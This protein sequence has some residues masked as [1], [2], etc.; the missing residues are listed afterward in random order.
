[1]NDRMNP[2]SY[3]GIVKAV[4]PDNFLEVTSLHDSVV[5]NGSATIRIPCNKVFPD[6]Q[7]FTT[8]YDVGD[9]VI[10]HGCTGRIHM[11]WPIQRHGLRA[12]YP[13]DASLD[14]QVPRYSLLL[15]PL[16]HDQT[17]P[18]LVADYGQDIKRRPSSFRFKVGDAV[19]IYDSIHVAPLNDRSYYKLINSTMI[20]AEVT[21]VDVSKGAEDIIV[22]MYECSF[23]K[24][25]SCLI[26][27]D[28]DEGISSV[29]ANPRER[30]FDAIEQNCSREHLGFLC[31]HFDIDV[32]TFS[33]LVVSK[34]VESASLQAL[35]WLQNECKLDVLSFKDELGNNL[36]HL[37]AKSAHATRFIREAGRG[38]CNI[39]EESLLDFSR[40]KYEIFSHLNNEGEL[41]IQTIIRRG[42]AK[43][44]DAALSP[45]CGFA[46]DLCIGISLREN[47]LDLILKSLHEAGDPMMQCIFESFMSFF[48]LN[49]Q[50]NFFCVRLFGGQILD[51]EW[52]WLGW[53]DGSAKSLMRF[54][55]DWC[56]HPRNHVQDFHT[57]ASV[58]VINGCFSPFKIFYEADKTAFMDQSYS[59]KSRRDVGEFT[60]CELFETNKVANSEYFLEVDIIA[61]CIIG[62]K[63]QDW[64][65]GGKEWKSDRG[66]YDVYIREI[67]EHAVY[68]DHH[69]CPSLQYHLQNYCN[70]SA[71]VID[72][73]FTAIFQER[74]ALLQDDE[75]V[76]GRQKIFAYL[77]QK[78]SNI[79]FDVLLPLIHRQCW[80]L[81]VMIDNGL[82]QLGSLAARC[83]SLAKISRDLLFLEDGLFENMSLK[84]CLCFAAVQY[85]DL[86]SLQ[87]L[88]ESFGA[89]TELIGG[90]NLLH[91]SAYM[92]RIEIIAWLSSQPI[93]GS[94]ITQVCG[95]NGFQGAFAIHI[96]ARQGHLSA[97]DLMIHLK[98]PLQDSIGRFPED[99]AKASSHQFVLD[100]AEEREAPKKLELD[101]TKLFEIIRDKGRSV[102]EIK[103][104]IQHSTCLDTEKWMDCDYLSYDVAGP[105]GYS[106]GDVLHECCKN[107]HLDVKVW[108]CLRLYFSNAKY[109]LYK[110]FW[111]RSERT[112]EQL[113]ELKVKETLSRNDLIDFQIDQAQKH[114]SDLLQKKWFKKISCDEPS[115]SGILTSAMNEGEKE[116]IET[117]RAAILRIHVLLKMAQTAKFAAPSLLTEGCRP[118]EIRDLILT[119]S[120]VVDA[121]ISEG[122]DTAASVRLPS[123]SWYHS[124]TFD[125]MNMGNLY[126]RIEYDDDHPIRKQIKYQHQS[127]SFLS[128]CHVF[129]AIEG[130]S[131]L[132]I[133]CL[134]NVDGWTAPMELDMVRISSYLGNSSITELFLSGESKSLVSSAKDRQIEAI[135]GAGEALRYRDLELLLERFDAPSDQ[136]E[137]LSDKRVMEI[138]ENATRF[139]G[140]LIVC[141]L[142]GYLETNH[143]T[144]NKSKL[145]TLNF[146]VERMGYPIDDVILAAAV[147]I[148]HRAFRFKE[149]LSLLEIIQHMMKVKRVQPIHYHE[150]MRH[151]C[152]VVLLETMISTCEEN[153][154]Q[155][156]SSIWEWMGEMARL[157]IDIQKLGEKYVV[158]NPNILSAL[159]DLEEKQ[160]EE[161]SRFAILKTGA[162]LNDIHNALDHGALSL[163]ARDRGGALLTHISA[164]YNRVDVL[165][166]L[167]NSKGMELDSLDGE[168][169]TVLEVARVSQ[170]SRVIEWIAEWNARNTIA[171]FL[172]RNYYRA[173]HLRRRKRTNNAAI[174]I[175]RYVRG[176]STRK[177]YSGALT[178]RLEE[179]RQFYIVWGNLLESILNF[180]STCWSSI[181]EKLLD[182]KVGIDDDLFIKTDEKLK[183]ALNVAVKE[184]DV[185]NNNSCLD[186]ETAID[187][188]AL[189]IDDEENL[190]K[191]GK[192]ATGNEWMSFQMSSHVVKFLQQG[193]KKYRSFFV[194]RMQ[195][196]ARGE[197][198]RILRKPLKGSNSHIFET[199]L[200][201]KSG[202]RILW[203]EEGENI[204]VWYV[205]KHKQV[206]RLMQLIDDS[207]SRSARQQ[208]PQT[209]SDELQSE[210]SITLDDSK[211]KVLLD[212]VGNV[213]LKVYDVDFNNINEMTKDSW[214][215][216]LHLTEE[217]RDIVEAEGTVLVLGRSGTGKTVCI[218]NRIEHDRQAR[219]GQDPTF[220]QLFVARSVRL[221]K[222]VQSTVGDDHRTSFCTYSRLLSDIETSLPAQ[223]QNQSFSPSHK[224]NFHRFRQEFY[225]ISPSNMKV[226]ALILWT[227]VRTFLKGSIEAFQSPNGILSR[228][229]FMQVEKLGRNR[230]RIPRELRE[231]VYDEFIRY[232]NYRKERKLWDDCDRL[233][234]LM[235]RIKK[236][237]EDDPNAFGQVQKSRLYVDEVQDYT[238]L[239][240]LLFFYLSGPNG[241]FLAGDPAQSVVEGTEFRFEEVRSVGHF[242]GC[243]IQKPKTVNINFR[244][245]SGILNCA[246]GVLDLMFTHFPSSAKQLKKDEGLFQG[247]RPGILSGASIDQLNVLLS[248]KLQGAVVLTHDDSASH[249]RQR[250]KGYN[251]SGI[252]THQT[253]FPKRN[254]LSLIFFLACVWNKRGK[255]PG[256]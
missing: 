60:Q 46:W 144:D 73:G 229:D 250:L 163:S 236:S 91:F 233:R 80:A 195:Q 10:T 246:G 252:T 201:Q 214:T 35:S 108:I 78:E 151:L 23:G 124:T 89:P 131:E 53:G 110:P 178:L 237:N 50:Y 12:G 256:V 97:C 224:I 45:H 136:I 98:L 41:W 197:R 13:D 76:E 248:D 20:R 105:L 245:H 206:S 146:L 255:G 24:G 56:E 164:A 242:V 94:L 166:W 203:T 40:D 251:V 132:A 147:F 88:V 168:G 159:H 90:W 77:L 162:S 143:D 174:S 127:R 39:N 221:C 128:G 1:M 138:E 235:I 181:R 101:V 185:H 230:C 49:K 47:F 253:I 57:Q 234:H 238:Q 119:H 28:S 26:L 222:Y 75:N 133:F 126:A 192:D 11:L 200:E 81:C 103:V 134:H 218:C 38:R 183:K 61:A 109:Y 194:R 226:S 212:I 208:M 48:A 92:G 114:L 100:W 63:K 193:D 15:D 87:Y 142:S 21:A 27:D 33:D 231:Y 150:R 86:Q 112:A 6:F 239:E 16:R 156:L 83:P 199:Y 169:R 106:F 204:V 8:Q 249:W 36:L 254:S 139:S 51:E 7:D 5:G 71:G 167:I 240:I 190:S 179:S 155:E 243:V 217:E 180:S 158:T 117:V 241:L 66:K 165:E 198:S 54:H 65:S 173:I 205:A 148:R 111:A 160:R 129:L 137:D 157:G 154:D 175:Q 189:T 118:E 2:N 14:V 82:L 44:L 177:F 43:A 247:C 30:L 216:Q 34:A 232:E 115:T 19:N 107:V 17:R 220:T 104:F 52:D 184:E 42:D 176:Y 122:Y 207:K 191:K 123:E 55:H 219:V 84:S 135:L 215:P 172:R 153:T 79:Q 29:N 186:D 67:V 152:Q 188:G 244:S 72:K 210:K 113:Q 187:L 102:E 130:Y 59:V 69:D 74:I 96:A 225:N 182:I 58:Y 121:L 202:H 95:R 64:G 140:S 93:W 145:T 70:R 120:T 170:A 85:D 125:P 4:L 211:E 228:K 62:R 196:L 223:Q 9:L 31:R 18:R 99:Y 209:L 37:I 227:I 213:P 116:H 149:M 68:C 171:S 141:V 22:A 161:W 3:R 32:S 25:L